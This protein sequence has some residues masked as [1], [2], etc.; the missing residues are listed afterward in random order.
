MRLG[1]LARKLSLRPGEIIEFLATQNIATEGHNTRLNN[2]QLSL[3]LQKFA[4]TLSLESV[5]QTDSEIPEENPPL[6]PAPEDNIP[7]RQIP[8]TPVVIHEINDVINTPSEIVSEQEINTPSEI[9]EVIKAPKVELPGLK[10]IGK[11]DLPEPKKKETDPENPEIA[12]TGDASPT[13]E[14]KQFRNN[15]RKR[16]YSKNKMDRPRKNPIATQRER[17]ARDEKKKKQEEARLEKE[18]RTQNYLKKVKPAVPTKRARIIDEQVIEM[19]AEEKPV[20]K[21]LLGK[22]WKWFRRE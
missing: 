20:P 16:D 21:T 9:V 5:L 4:P 10:V 7:P 12:T 2:D 15:D 14:K 6:D 18:R 11:I 19:E 13:E 1:Q 22:F 8:E 17:E 3:V